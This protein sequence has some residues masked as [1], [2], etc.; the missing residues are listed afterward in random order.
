[1]WTRYSVIDETALVPIGAHGH[2]QRVLDGELVAAFLASKVGIF[3][4]CRIQRRFRRRRLTLTQRYAVEQTDDALGA[5]AQ[6]MRRIRLEHDMTDVA[7]PR[8]W[9]SLAK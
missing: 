5:R 2:G 7:D 8:L 1:M 6:I 3:G 9:S 4:E